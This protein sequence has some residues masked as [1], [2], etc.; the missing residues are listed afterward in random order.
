MPLPLMCNCESICNI[1]CM[2][3]PT[4]EESGQHLCG[5]VQTDMQGQGQGQARNSREVQKSRTTSVTLGRAGSG[6]T[7][8]QVCH[9]TGMEK[10]CLGEIWTSKYFSD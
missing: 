1:Q 10:V 8:Q 2:R 7:S 3:Q 9:N 5:V 6:E 4:S